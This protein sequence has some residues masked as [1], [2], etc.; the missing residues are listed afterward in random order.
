MILSVWSH[1]PGRVV[2]DIVIEQG[3]QEGG[4]VALGDVGTAE[5]NGAVELELIQPPAGV[6]HGVVV[7]SK[8]RNVV[9]GLVG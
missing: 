1:R 2:D 6:R 8:H 9:H 7:H 5:T 3:L 4:R